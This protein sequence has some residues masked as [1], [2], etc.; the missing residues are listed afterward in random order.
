MTTIGF[1]FINEI[2]A[3]FLIGSLPDSW[4]TLVVTVMNSAPNDEVTIQ[5]VK[6]S[7]L[8]EETR[9]R[10][11]EHGFNLALV[12]ENRGRS[13]NREQSISRC[14]R[15]NNQSKYRGPIKCYHC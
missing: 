7:F 3:L 2:N 8:N 4:D 11:I 5:M 12:I 10:M 13:N 6:D 9:R 15:S 14:Y 1:N